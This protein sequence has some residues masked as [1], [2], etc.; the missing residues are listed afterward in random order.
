M[1]WVKRVSV[2]ILVLGL[3]GAAAAWLYALRTLPQVD[4]SVAVAGLASEVRIERDAHGIPTI[5]ASSPEAAL[6]GLGYA[7]AQDRRW[8]LE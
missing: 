6:F 1:K 5:K 2:G 7:H 4:G 8:Q 3:L